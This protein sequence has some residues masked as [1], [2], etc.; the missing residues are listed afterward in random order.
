MFKTLFNYYNATI[1]D[2]TI[3]AYSES[4]DLKMSKQ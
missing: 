1:F 4:D 3:Q 2:I